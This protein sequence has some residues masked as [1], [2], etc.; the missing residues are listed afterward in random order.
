MKAEV[1]IGVNRKKLLLQTILFTIMSL[2]GLLAGFGLAE[3]AKFLEPWIWKAIGI[4]VCLFAL[5]AAGAKM[6]RR[7]DSA[8]GITFSKE[9]INDTSSEISLGMVKWRD[10]T[11]IDKSACLKNGLLIIEVKN[12]G[13]YRKRAKNS[14]IGRLLDQNVRKFGTPVVID[15]SYLDAT[16]DSLIDLALERIN[17]RK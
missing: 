4:V 12:G 14:A 13:E 3:N 17:K 7:S 2:V 1:Y 9:G 15:A 11:T 6:K 8:A 5:L 10:I 16:L